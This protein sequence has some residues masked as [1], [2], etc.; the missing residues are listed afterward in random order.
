MP[1]VV[2]FEITAEKSERAVAFY[3]KVF[4]WKIEKWSGPMEYWMAT[5]GP[6]DQM[7]INGAIMPK[8][9]SQ[10]VIL[11]MDVPNLKEALAKITEAGGKQVSPEMPI[12]GI[13]ISAYCMDTEGNQFGVLQ[14]EMP[15]ANNP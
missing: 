11:W 1:R 14:P 5:T 12:P 8:T 13:G 10:N 4:G 2:H 7:G 9:V 6:A 15:M 3:E